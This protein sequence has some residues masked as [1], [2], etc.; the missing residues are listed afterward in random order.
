MTPALKLA[1]SLLDV[2]LQ[3]ESL[4]LFV[5]D[6][7]TDT[8]G[9]PAGSPPKRKIHLSGVFGC[10]L[11]RKMMGGRESWV[12]RMATSR[13]QNSNEKIGHGCRFPDCAASNIARKLL[14]RNRERKTVP[15]PPPPTHPSF[16]KCSAPSFSN[17]LGHQTQDP[18]GRGYRSCERAE[19]SSSGPTLRYRRKKA[20]EDVSVSSF[21]FR[22]SAFLT[23]IIGQQKTF[24]K[25]LLF[26]GLPPFS[27]THTPFFFTRIM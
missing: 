11:V 3:N 23:A 16:S 6:T 14:I 5:C 26:D 17:E 25:P 27:S 22:T 19:T 13:L 12:R 4:A 21:W 18:G 7:D 1:S 10:T 20:K 9:P 24:I 8:T 2:P 15:S